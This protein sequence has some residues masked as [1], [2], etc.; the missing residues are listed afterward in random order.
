[1]RM[2]IDLLYGRFNMSPLVFGVSLAMVAIF[3]F[4]EWVKDERKKP[5]V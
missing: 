3:L 4:I 1:M 5:K 2:V